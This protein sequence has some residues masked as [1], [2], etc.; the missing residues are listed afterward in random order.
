MIGEMPCSI[1]G[2]KKEKSLCGKFAVMTKK[3]KRKT[4]GIRIPVVNAMD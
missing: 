1:N 3:P 4:I 2:F